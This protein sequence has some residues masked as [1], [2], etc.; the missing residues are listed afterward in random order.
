MSIPS[1]PSWLRQAGLPRRLAVAACVG[2]L[3][4]AAAPALTA[5]AAVGST[6]VTESFSQ[7]FSD[8]FTG[9]AIDKTHWSVYDNAA[10]HLAHSAKNVV[11]HDGMLTLKTAYDATVGKFTTGGVCLCPTRGSLAQTYGEWEYRARVSAGDSRALAMLWPDIGWP[12]EIDFLEM[13]GQGAQGT[14]QQSTQTMHYDADNKMIHSSQFA[15]FTQWHTIGVKWGPG[16]LQYLLDGQPS[17]T[18]ASPSVPAQLM[19]LGL[20]TAPQIGGPTT[21]PVTYDID[22][23]KQYSYTGAAGTAPAAT[24]GVVATAGDASATVSWTPPADTGNSLL[25]GYTVTAQPGGQ[26]MTVS[27]SVNNDPKTSATFSGLTP[28]VSY[29]FT[30]AARNAFGAGPTSAPSAPVVVTGTP[31]TVTAAPTA[32]FVKNSTFGSSATSSD[33]PVR[34]SWATTQGSAPVCGQQVARAGLSGQATPLRVSSATATTLNDRLAA[35]GSPVG[36]TVQATGCNGLSTGRVAGPSYTY[37][38]TQQDAAG[39]TSSG[40]WSTVQCAACSSGSMAETR[41]AGASLSFPVA[42]AY[43]AALVVRTGPQQSPFNVYVDGAYVGLFREGGTTNVS[44]QIAFTTTWATPG[45]HTIKVVNVG[46][47]TKPLLDVDALLSLT[48]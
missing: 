3:S 5:G 23:V 46:P 1:V 9:T 40:T 45:D 28:G 16:F 14:R 33:V 38:V 21:Q 10:G 41:T 30:V 44:R 39:V 36:Y 12:P 19:R 8:D 7:V 27:R 2:L 13:G 43:G 48:K 25:T 11:V 26:T 22:W 34:V 15:D 31:P 17:Y 4:T 37:H 47:S 6:P 24:G 20:A 29:T 35:A 32:A 18:I 42:N